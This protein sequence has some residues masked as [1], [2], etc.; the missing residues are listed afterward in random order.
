MRFSML[1]CK[2]LAQAF[3]AVLAVRIVDPTWKDMHGYTQF[4]KVRVVF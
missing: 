3:F 4:M 2:F 1:A